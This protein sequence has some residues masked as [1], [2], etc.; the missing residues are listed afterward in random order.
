M[1]H[2][3]VE[4]LLE[5]AETDKDESD[6]AYFFAMLL[7]GEAIAK[8][9]LLGML[10]AISDDTKRHRYQLEYKLVRSNGLGDWSAVLDEALS[11]PASQYIV[12]EAQIERRELTRNCRDGEW[13][14]EAVSCL[15]AALEALNIDSET[16][17]A[18][19]DMKRWFR[20]FATLRNKT[21][22]HGA[23]RPSA[24]GEAVAFLHKSISLIYENFHMFQ[25]P[26]VY[27]YRNLSG[28]YRVTTLGND[29][30][31]FEYL[32]RESSYS[33]PNGVYLH[34]GTPVLVPLLVGDPELTAFYLPNGGFDGRTYNLLSYVT[35]DKLSEDARPYLTPPDVLRDSE[36]HGYGE[37]LAKGHCFSN[38]PEPAKTYVSR[39]NLEND[40]RELVL[41]DRHAII[42]LQ[43]AGGVGKTSSTL[44]VIEELYRTE[45][46][47]VVVWFSAR[48]IDLLSS[49]PRTVRRAVF[50][51]ADVADQYAAFVLPPE[52]LKDKKF[53][54][55]EFFEQ[56]LGKCDGGTCLFVFDNFE[57]V[58]NPVDMYNWIETFVRPPNKVLITTR[59]R[60][61]KGDYPLEV[62]GMTDLEARTLVDRTA[63]HLGV[64]ALLADEN[65]DELVSQS[66]GHPYVI[67]IILGEVV[68]RK[69]FRSPRHVVAASDEILT[70]LFER[71]F[72][73]L[74]PCGQRAFL[75][76]A[77][78]N[79]AVPRI[80]LE[81]VL[82][83]STKERAEVE[84]GIQSLL[85]Y[86]LA[87]ARNPGED[88]QEF[89][90]LPFAAQ[91]FGKKRLQ[92]SVLKSA[93]L[94][95]RD[96]LQMFSPSPIGDVDLNLSKRLRSFI[97]N[98]SERID[99]GAVFLDFE[100]ILNMVCRAYNPGWLLLAQWHIERESEEDLGNAIS[101]IE[102]FLQSD[103][104]DAGALEAWRILGYAYY[105]LG[106][107]LGEVNAFVERAQFDSVAFNEVS[108]TANLLNSK[109]QD[110]DMESEGKIML[111]RRLLDVL[112]RRQS[113][114]NA[115][116]LS[117]MAWLALHVRQDEKA[118]QYV[119][120]GL[121]HDLENMHC[122]RIAERLKLG[123]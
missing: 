30:V 38:A 53:D 44:Q 59:L 36:T 40:L 7:A 100:P 26:W 65:I 90:S 18:R 13:Q 96:V 76:L 79:S 54:R 34:L 66:G 39:P 19:T 17:T 70:A 62:R 63:T 108:R 106:N 117:R 41:D 49:G 89:I 105:K 91:A 120:Q 86:S 14:F 71:T 29:A 74:S 119:R 115:D 27:L 118:K 95:D 33:L 23:T 98:L 67:K 99:E 107:V 85:Q 103:P 83:Q 47:E 57:T 122:L 50:S 77:S 60:D 24:A 45:R 3:L 46:Y 110:L 32:K 21:R 123:D 69:T 102:S 20:L 61:F 15:K 81:A 101:K 43:G 56:Q 9:I 92:T 114:A 87:E 37:L 104:S 93:I 78:W 5:R 22:G 72:T 112:D 16:V 58:Q 10:A 28:K 75:T 68:F 12:P 6:F 64:R 88:G 42:T 8:L 113:E 109:Y 51:R 73:A 2:R 55:V 52:V 4:Q 25:R 94:S 11:G 80:A 121:E 1:A 35:D 31:E 48:D 111:A 82:I 97:R 116:D 84:D